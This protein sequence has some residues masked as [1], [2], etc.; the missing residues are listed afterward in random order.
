MAGINPN[1]ANQI[2]APV[3]GRTGWE[4]FKDGIKKA[5]KSIWKHRDAIMGVIEGAAMLL[6]TDPDLDP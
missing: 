3:K 5:G 4:K 6:A 2:V 1:D